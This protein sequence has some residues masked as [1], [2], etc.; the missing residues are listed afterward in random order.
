MVR[1]P[2]SV[3]CIGAPQRGQWSPGLRWAMTSP[4]CTPPRLIA[5]RIAL[6]SSRCSR[7]LVAVEAVGRP[8]W[9]D[10][11]LPEGL[12]GEQVADAGD[13]VLV[14]QAG[15]HRGARGADRGAEVAQADLARVGPEHLESGSSRTRPSRRLSKSRSAPP[16]SKNSV[17]GPTPASI[18]RRP[19]DGPTSRRPRP[20]R[21]PAG[22]QDPAAH[23][24]VDAERTGDGAARSRTTSTCRGRWATSSRRP[25]SASRT[26]GHV[27][28]ADPVVGVVDLRDPPAECRTLDHG[29]GGLHLGQLGH[30]VDSRVGPCRRAEAA[31]S[32]RAL[33]LAAAA[34]VRSH[35]RQV[36]AP[37]SLAAT[38][39]AIT[40]APAVGAGVDLVGREPRQQRRQVRRPRGAVDRPAR[41]R[42]AG[43]EQ[44][45]ADCAVGSGAAGRPAPLSTSRSTRR[46]APDGVRPSTWCT[47]SIVA[48]SRNSGARYSAAASV[49]DPPAAAV[50]DRGDHLVGDDEGQAHRARWPALP[51]RLPAARRSRVAQPRS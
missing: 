16:S 37:P 44:H 49:T 6:R 15:L 46:T 40:F 11:G 5:W 4:V 10:R 3:R 24:E 50:G 43:G 7:D 12:V 23:P 27:R 47:R 51:A 29:A 18:G 20:V 33:A 41:S 34:A 39:L 26:R 19:G 21:R 25:S 1:P 30:L 14:E 31:L 2:T 9:R 38:T 22:H 35:S 42:P 17:N 45:R 32:G 28:P 13:R 48:P 8:F 36:Q